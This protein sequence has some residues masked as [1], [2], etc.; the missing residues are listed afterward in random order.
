MNKWVAIGLTFSALWLT[1]CGALREVVVE[2]PP[3]PIGLEGLGW[4]C[5]P[6]DTVRNIYISK[7]E[8]MITSGEERYET[9]LSIYAVR[10]SL[11]YFSAVNAGFEIL[12][13]TIEKDSIRVIDRLN[14]ILY[15]TPVKRRLGY[16]HPVDYTDIQRLVSTYFLC[17]DLDRGREVDFSTMVFEFSEELVRKQIY[18]GRESLKMDKFEFYHTR[19]DKYLVGERLD[20]GFRIMS[21][22][23]ISDLEVKAS[24]GERLYN[25]AIPVKMDVN[26][27]RYSIVRL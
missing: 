15:L 26:L 20:D 7:A 17:D 23:I 13:G 19:T 5:E 14:K 2:E 4:I 25:M 6:S 12:R 27:R 10:D 8:A 9:Q 21:N 18:L 3:K 16:S 11:I 24:G 22:F 1:Q